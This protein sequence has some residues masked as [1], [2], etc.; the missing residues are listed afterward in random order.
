MRKEK[1]IE[2]TRLTELRREE[3]KRNNF[4]T[5]LLIP[6]TLASENTPHNSQQ[7]KRADWKQTH[8]T[9]EK[10]A[11]RP[12]KAWCELLRTDDIGQK[13]NELPVKKTSEAHQEREG[14][15]TRA[16]PSSAGFLFIR[17]TM[18]CY[19]R[20]VKIIINK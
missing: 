18:T 7:R 11:H 6:T 9:T 13:I 10:D 20:G 4:V 5:E 3:S 12:E 19:V 16:A 14:V 15:E 2:E 1:T 17:R 8:C